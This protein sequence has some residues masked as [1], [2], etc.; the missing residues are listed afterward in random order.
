M[1]ERSRNKDPL[2]SRT[3]EIEKSKE[4]RIS[5]PARLK[6]ESLYDYNANV[7]MPQ[8]GE[9]CSLLETS[10]LNF[11]VCKLYLI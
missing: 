4:S 6:H 5:S 1:L 8:K 10:Q 11:F 3:E 2:T 7:E 9:L